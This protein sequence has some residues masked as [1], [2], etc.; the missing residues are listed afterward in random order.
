MRC[1]EFV[2]M[3]L[4]IGGGHVE[5]VAKSIVGQRLKRSGVRWSTDGG[6]RVLIL[7]TLVKDGRGLAAWAKSAIGQRHK[8]PKMESTPL[9][10]EWLPTTASSPAPHLR[11]EK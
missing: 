1:R 10:L 3:G 7:R 9:G 4:P 11:R 8:L 2:G 6:Q 5:T